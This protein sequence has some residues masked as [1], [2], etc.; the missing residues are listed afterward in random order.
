MTNR[1]AYLRAIEFDNSL[2]IEKEAV[3]LW[4]LDLD[5]PFRWVARPI[6]QLFFA[7][8]LHV[9]WFLKRLPLPQFSAHKTLQKTICWFCKYFVSY[10]ANMLILRHF[11]TESN[12]LNFLADNSTGEAPERLALYPKKIGLRWRC[13]GFA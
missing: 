2:P 12:I 6:L 7:I 13:R 3:E 10:E 1:S 4:L 8:L 5:N 9:T 11:T